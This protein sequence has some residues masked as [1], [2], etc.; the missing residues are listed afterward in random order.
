[1]QHNQLQEHAE[2]ATDLE[3]RVVVLEREV[4]QT[5]RLM[6]QMLE[7]LEKH[8]KVDF[9]GDGRIGEDS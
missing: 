3:E 8:F 5:R 9:D 4:E 2:R 7:R 6:W 1:M